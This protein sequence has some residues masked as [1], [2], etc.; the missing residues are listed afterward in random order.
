MRFHNVC[1][2]ADRHI[3]PQAQAHG[4]AWDHASHV[5]RCAV[6]LH[7]YLNNTLWARLSGMTE[8]WATAADGVGEAAVWY[9]GSGT[10]ALWERE[11]RNLHQEYR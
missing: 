2:N 1:N 10:A 11:L 6:H 9:H 4:H 3:P 7:A 8:A 5:Y